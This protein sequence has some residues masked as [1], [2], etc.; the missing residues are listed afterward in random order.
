MK[1]DK[2]DNKEEDDME[3][4]IE[5]VESENVDGKDGF[6]AEDITV[7]AP[8]SFLPP[9]FWA[10]LIFSLASGD[11]LHPLL[12]VDFSSIEGDNADKADNSKAKQWEVAARDAAVERVFSQWHGI[13]EVTVKQQEHREKKLWQNEQKIKLA[14]TDSKLNQMANLHDGYVAHYNMLQVIRTNYWG[15]MSVEERMEL[16]GKQFEPLA[17]HEKE[18]K[19]MEQYIDLT[20]TSPL[21]TGIIVVESGPSSINGSKSIT[22]TSPLDTDIELSPVNL[23][24]QQV[25]VSEHS[26][27]NSSKSLITNHKKLDPSWKRK[28]IGKK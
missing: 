17:N 22:T 18:Q 9:S 19:A 5:E 26:S 28:A 14:K 23:F 10:F 3:A 6:D 2:D 21:V 24:A 7:E 8:R 13:T 20:N 11:E 15:E 4:D 27:S 12:T 16:K 1:G 25:L